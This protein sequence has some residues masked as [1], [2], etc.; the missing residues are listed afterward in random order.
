MLIDALKIVNFL[1]C[2]Y[3]QPQQGIIQ[4]DIGF[5]I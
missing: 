1:P 4:V 2:L 3:S 5:M